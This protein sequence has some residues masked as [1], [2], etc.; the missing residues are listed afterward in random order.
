MSV[1]SQ[2]E[3][4]EQA[5]YDSYDR[6]EIDNAQLQRELRDLQ[7]DYRSAAEDAARDAYEAEL[8]RW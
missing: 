5:I 7:R 8:E 1:Q 6:G 3:R 4:E 2:Y